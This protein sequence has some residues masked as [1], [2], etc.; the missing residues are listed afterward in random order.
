MRAFMAI[1]DIVNN[2][3]LILFARHEFISYLC[4]HLLQQTE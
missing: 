3:V 2:N 1:P 4:M